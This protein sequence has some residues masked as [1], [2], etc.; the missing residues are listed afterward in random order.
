MN[1]ISTTFQISLCLACLL[2]SILFAAQLLGFIPDGYCDRLRSRVEL[3]E[4]IAIEASLAIQ[5]GNPLLLEQTLEEVVERNPKILHARLTRADGEEVVALQAPAS[6]SGGRPKPSIIQVP[7]SANGEPWGTVEL[8]LEPLTPAGAWHIVTGDTARLLMFSAAVGVVVFFVYL[9]RVLQHLDPSEVVPERVRT[10]LDTLAEG[11]VVLDSSQRIVLANSTFASS[12]GADS[13]DLFGK[14]A[15]DFGWRFE[16][17]VLP[18][19]ELPWS[20]SMQ[21]RKSMV[22]QMLKLGNHRS[23]TRTFRVNASPILDEKGACQGSFASFDDV[24]VL[25]ERNAS[26]TAMLGRLRES[27]DQIRRQNCELQVLATQDPLTGALNRRSFFEQFERFWHAAQRNHKPLSC[28][29]VDV[30]H[31]KSVNDNHGHAQGDA[32]LKGVVRSFSGRSKKV[33]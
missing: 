8:G 30:D 14:S 28:I 6:E 33:T 10:T 23:G 13:A 20:V 9:R 26:L 17:E 31:F 11:L 7:I 29:M 22:G 2:I 27:R 19:N 16:D 1:R 18:P 12:I 24:T 4:V 3:C 25:E 32:V 5:H 21:R 15:A